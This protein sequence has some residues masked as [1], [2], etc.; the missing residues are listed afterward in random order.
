MNPKTFKYSESTDSNLKQQ[1]AQERKK[2]EE[3][4]K[5]VGKHCSAAMYYRE[6]H[7]GRIV[8]LEKVVAELLKDR[9]DRKVLETSLKKSIKTMQE[10]MVQQAARIEE[11]TKQVEAD[12]RRK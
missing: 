7:E 9:D 5:T 12:N 4:A 1:L 2:R 3:L 10:V 6:K 8:E 11:L